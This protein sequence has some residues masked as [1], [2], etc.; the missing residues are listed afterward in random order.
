MQKYI[1]FMVIQQKVLNVIWSCYKTNITVIDSE[2]KITPIATN[3]ITVALNRLYFYIIVYD[4]GD[5]DRGN[6]VFMWIFYWFH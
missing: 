5:N 4:R 1:S 3:N 2:A 6:N